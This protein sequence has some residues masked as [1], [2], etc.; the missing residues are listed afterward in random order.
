MIVPA[1]EAVLPL[2]ATEWPL[3]DKQ[4]LVDLDAKLRRELVKQ[5]TPG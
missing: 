4:I 2:D 3:E 5:R 1:M